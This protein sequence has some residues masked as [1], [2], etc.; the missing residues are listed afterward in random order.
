MKIR[1][2][3]V[4]LLLLIAQV[5]LMVGFCCNGDGCPNSLV[6]YVD[7]DGMPTGRFALLNEFGVRLV[8]IKGP[9]CTCKGEIDKVFPSQSCPHCAEARCPRQDCGHSI[10]QHTCAL[11]IRATPGTGIIEVK[12]KS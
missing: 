12:E 10:F 2:F 5:G 9:S 11:N 3:F 7:E 1:L 8:M 4:V 6:Q